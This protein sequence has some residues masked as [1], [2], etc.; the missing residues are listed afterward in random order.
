MSE[1]ILSSTGK[2]VDDAVKKVI[3]DTFVDKT[4]FEELKTKISTDLSNKQDKL[5]SSTNIR[6]INGKSVL[7]E[8]NLEVGGDV[9][10]EYVDEQDSQIKTDLNALRTEI[11]S[12]IGQVDTL[13]GSGVIV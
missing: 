1:Y 12:L 11:E 10:K 9:T 5:I 7:G 8:G 2:Q 13:V 4:T 3:N 6:T